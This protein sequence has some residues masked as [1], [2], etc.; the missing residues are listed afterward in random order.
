[1]KRSTG[2]ARFQ[3]LLVSRQLFND[4]EAHELRAAA[5]GRVLAALDVQQVIDS[6]NVRDWDADDQPVDGG[7]VK[8]SAHGHDGFP[9][10]W[11]MCGPAVVAL[12]R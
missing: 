3:F 5:P 9:F 7:P 2:D 12:A 4:G 11:L 6:G 8:A 10:V 1:M